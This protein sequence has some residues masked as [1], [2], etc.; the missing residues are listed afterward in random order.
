MQ[1]HGR[2][3]F[4]GKL[5]ELKKETPFFHRDKT[6]EIEEPFRYCNK[7]WIFN[8]GHQGYAIGWWRKNKH[9]DYLHYVLK[10]I[11][12][13]MDFDFFKA[14]LTAKAGEASSTDE[15]EVQ[16]SSQESEGNASMGDTIVV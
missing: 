13:D 14:A 15:R 2:W 11:G 8:I 12:R 9:D 16:D 7:T 4:V 3:L 5:G 1:T 6:A 10:V